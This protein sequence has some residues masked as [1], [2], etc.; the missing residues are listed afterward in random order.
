[1]DGSFRFRPSPPP[2]HSGVPGPVTLPSVY[3]QLC[4]I[5][6]SYTILSGEEQLT[7]PRGCGLTSVPSLQSLLANL[8]TPPTIQ[9]WREQ[10]LSGSSK[11]CTRHYFYCSMA[12]LW[13]SFDQPRTG[14]RKHLG[15]TNNHPG[16]EENASRIQFLDLPPELIILI[17]DWLPAE[18]AACFALCNRGLCQILG[19]TFIKLRGASRNAFLSVLARDLPQY[20]WCHKCV[21]LHQISAI[22]WPGIGTYGGSPN[23][24][25]QTPSYIHFFGFGLWIDFVHVQLVMK[26][27]FYGPDHGFPLEAF[28]HF[29]V[30]K[31]FWKQLG[32]GQ[33]TA[34]SVDTKI[35]DNE[36][37]MR[38]QLCVLLPKHRRNKFYSSTF[39]YNLCQH[40]I[41]TTHN[42]GPWFQN[43]MRSRVEQLETQENCR[44]ETL[45]CSECYMEFTIDAADFGKRGVAV[46][47]TRW[48]NFG[49]GLDPEDPKWE[50]HFRW[51]NSQGY[52]QSLP[53]GSIRERFESQG[54]KLVKDLTAD[55]ILKLLRAQLQFHPSLIGRVRF[56]IAALVFRQ[57]VSQ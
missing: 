32:M 54:G 2:I 40:I 38:S 18:F 10:N 5:S 4:D 51:W 45:H 35:V 27:H 37:L 20:Y 29:E 34:L 14:Y 50:S 41:S 33:I 57:K 49:S 53:L 31:S 36:F 8:D 46:F 44:T 28:Q 30:R 55:N 23:C 12:W 16:Q 42:Y 9:Q 6:F 3:H 48:T 56:E 19:S 24:L 1:M 7:Q 22:S 43:L 26:R 13:R 15:Q 47:I 17:A 52:H 39:P 25:R 21:R 11:I